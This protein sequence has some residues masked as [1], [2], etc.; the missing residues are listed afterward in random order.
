MTHLSTQPD[1]ETR[2]FHKIEM[3][4]GDLVIFDGKLVHRSGT[5]KSKKSRYAYTWH[6]FDSGR[7]SWEEGNWIP[8]RDFLAYY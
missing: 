7:S 1:W 6:L 2:K 4:P 5:N 3:D 8:K